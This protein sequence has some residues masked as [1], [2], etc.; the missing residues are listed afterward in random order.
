MYHLLGSYL[1]DAPLDFSLLLSVVVTRILSDP[2]NTLS[3][4][5]IPPIYKQFLIL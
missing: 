4:G 2:I 3:Q 5:M 1:A